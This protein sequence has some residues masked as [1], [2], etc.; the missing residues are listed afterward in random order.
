MCPLPR[1]ARD[2]YVAPVMDE[3]LDARLSANQANWDE[4]VAIHA[5]SAFYDVE[6]WLRD[7]PGLRQWE[8]EVLG[9]VAG[10]DVVHLQCHFGLDT[11]ALADA[12]ASVTGL[13]FSGAA[14]AQARSLADRA[15]LVSRATFVEADVVDAAEV[16]GPGRFDLV[17]VSLGAL[18][19]LPSVERWAEQVAALLRPGGRLYL[20]DGHPLAW[21]LSWEDLRVETSYFE[22]QK[23]FVDDSAKTYTDG[24]TTITSTRVYEWNHSVGEIVTAVLGHGMGI[25]SLAEHDWTVY[26]RYPW[27]IK[28]DDGRWRPPPGAV[29]VPLS[30]TLTATKAG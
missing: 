13:D 16:L 30:L 21:S 8:L 29:R 4:R 15:E 25:D 2:G 24:D 20:H 18:S 3:P 17:Y 12:G 27:L 22:E 11:L 1:A 7:R 5:A 26:G 14:V 28:T 6:G 23:P 9:D 19:W 10:L